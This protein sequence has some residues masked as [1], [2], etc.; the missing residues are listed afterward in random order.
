MCSYPICDSISERGSTSMLYCGLVRDRGTV[1]TSTT[2]PTFASFSRSTN[3]AIGRVECPMVKNG[4][5]MLPHQT[6]A[7]VPPLEPVIRHHSIAIKIATRFPITRCDGAPTGA[8][9]CATGCGT[10]GQFELGRL[11]RTAP[12]SRARAVAILGDPRRPPLAVV[13]VGLAVPAARRLVVR[14]ADLRPLHEGPLD[15]R[16]VAEA[17]AVVAPEPAVAGDTE[18]PAAGLPLTDRE[19]GEGSEGGEGDEEDRD[20]LTDGAHERSPAVCVQR[21]LAARDTIVCQ[22]DRS[23][24]RMERNEIHD[25]IPRGDRPKEWPLGEALFIGGL[26]G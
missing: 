6:R 21:R 8:S 18:D 23:W 2:I 24:P 22:R 3:A 11:G 9:A 25:R 1:R 16:A 14:G 4:L 20:E 26:L 19:G 13:G 15:A 12:A 17:G 10:R 7:V 5:R